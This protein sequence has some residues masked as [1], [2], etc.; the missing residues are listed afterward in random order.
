VQVGDTLRHILQAEDKNTNPILTYSIR[1]ELKDL[2][3]NAQTGEIIWIPEKADLGLQEITVNVTDGFSIHSE[4]KKIQILVY[5]LPKIITEISTE[6]F[7]NIEYTHLIEA[8]DGFGNIEP[9]KDFFIVLDSTTFSN[10]SFEKEKSLL[11]LIPRIEEIGIQKIVFSLTDNFNN[12][13]KKEYSIN[14]IISP[15]ETEET[16]ETEEMA[17]EL[18]D[19]E[20]ETKRK[21]GWHPFN[22]DWRKT[23]DK[24]LWK[25]WEPFNNEQNPKQKNTKN[26]Q[27]AESL[28]DT[29]FVTEYDTIYQTLIDTVYKKT[30][31]PKSIKVSKHEQIEGVDDL[32][33][34]ETFIEEKPSMLDQKENPMKVIK[35]ETTIIDNIEIVVLESPLPTLPPPDGQKVNYQPD[36]EEQKWGK[37]AISKTQK[38]EVESEQQNY[39]KSWK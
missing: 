25:Q 11:T 23:K 22:E 36:F 16:T 4:G 34:T 26:S 19:Q 32:L 29:L 14:V 18:A 38:T 17:A 6:S 2:M 7:V 30:R 35:K 8:Q 33:P 3:L 24:F 5:S 10:I 9:N 20:S 15:C 27:I 21:K 31:A 12:I 28:K 37:E 1:S 13:I 39:K